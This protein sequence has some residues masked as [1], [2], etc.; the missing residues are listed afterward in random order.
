MAQAAVGSLPMPRYAPG[1][2]WAAGVR[3]RLAQ[4][5]ENSKQ[6]LRA[7]VFGYMDGAS[8]T[9]GL[10]AA[11]AGGG[12]IA[13]A[14]LTAAA[15]G[16]IAGAASMGA[17]EYVSVKTDNER[18]TRTVNEVR[19]R[20]RDDPEGVRAD[21]ALRL[22]A[23]H[24][25]LSQEEVSAAIKG[26]WAN[27]AVGEDHYITLK[28]GELPDDPAQPRNAAISSFTAF[29]LGA[30]LPT[31][32]YIGVA[33]GVLSGGLALPLSMAAGGLGLFGAGALSSRL[34]EGKWWKHGLRQL[35]AGAFT[36]GLAYAAATGLKAALGTSLAATALPAVAVAAGVSMAALV[37]YRLFRRRKSRKAARELRAEL[38]AHAPAPS[39]TMSNPAERAEI[40]PVSE[41]DDEP[42]PRT[43]SDPCPRLTGSP[44][45][46]PTVPS[47]S[48]SR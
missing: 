11:M 38:A 20:L 7:G 44:T 29:G 1:Q 15:S 25:Q 27:R 14:I 2:E 8:S 9:L 30:L 40:P 10:I 42:S 28:I 3:R 36:A 45:P 22:T 23:R 16:G 21:H 31:L 26:L 24:P 47:L 34:S 37:G 5:G 12:A 6:W 48:P 46:P 18:I 13:P 41:C 17:G 19:A 43:A 33:T 32:P 4:L 39:V 35:T